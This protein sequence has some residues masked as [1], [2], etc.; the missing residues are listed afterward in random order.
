MTALMLAI[1]LA[2]QPAAEA[3]IRAETG[4]DL[5][6]TA[7]GGPGMDVIVTDTAVLPDGSIAIA[8]SVVNRS[9]VFGCPWVIVVDE[10]GTVTWVDACGEMK[11]TG[12]SRELESGGWLEVLEN[13]TLLL[14]SYAEPRATGRNAETTVFRVTPGEG[15]ETVAVIGADD[16]MTYCP[17]GL[18]ARPDGSFL[19][20][21]GTC[22]YTRSFE[23]TWNSGGNG[24][25]RM[26]DQESVYPINAFDLIPEGSVL[27]DRDQAG[28]RRL[29]FRDEEG[30]TTMTCLLES[31]A[32]ETM[33]DIMEAG[34]DRILLAGSLDAT[35]WVGCVDNDYH[36]IWQTV[37][38]GFNGSVRD[39]AISPDGSLTLC[40]FSA[41]AYT[42]IAGSSEAQ[43]RDGLCRLDCTGSIE[44]TR[45]LDMEPALNLE[46]IDL[47]ED[48]TLVLAG[49]TTIIDEGV[50][51][52]CAG[53]VR[54]AGDGTALPHGP[55][56]MEVQI[57]PAVQLVMQP[58]LGFVAACGIC[59][60]E[61]AA[62]A[63]EESLDRYCGYEW[64]TGVTWIPLWASLSG[65]QAWLTYVGPLSRFLSEDRNLL[66]E[67]HAVCPDMN[68]IWAGNCH[69]RQEFTMEGFF[70]D[71]GEG[72]N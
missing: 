4:N 41:C 48:G 7:I 65:R 10:H 9:F 50:R 27:V 64:D 60:S 46:S 8:V 44:W 72:Y 25:L 63:L 43:E 57:P 29:V 55:T 59:E 47:M 45:T 23:F 52:I 69:A 30:E 33:I 5:F 1:A 2:S 20:L 56:G 58:P 15:T 42:G 67:L 68:M 13:G 49:G 34:D 31:L 40:G 53:L 26:S 71:S 14:A 24:G 54:I 6:F 22:A 66:E 32:P 17:I 3:A 35:P 28:V 21:G 39:M 36:L 19:I 62:R 11:I 70:D 61:R 38:E 12:V 51:L 16:D 37:V 18:R